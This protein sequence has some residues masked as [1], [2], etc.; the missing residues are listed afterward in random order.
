MSVEDPTNGLSVGDAA[1]N[2]KSVEEEGEM[3][4]RLMA[5]SSIDTR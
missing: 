5:E 4:G 1:G 3:T 2:G